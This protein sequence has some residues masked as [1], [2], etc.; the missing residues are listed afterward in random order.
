MCDWCVR[1]W[2]QRGQR[3]RS[4]KTFGGCSLPQGGSVGGGSAWKPSGL[5][6]SFK[7]TFLWTTSPGRFSHLLDSL[8]RPDKTPGFET[9]VHLLSWCLP[10][11]SNGSIDFGDFDWIYSV[12]YYN[13]QS[14]CLHFINCTMLLNC[15]KMWLIFK[16]S[17]F[18]QLF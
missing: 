13:G 1:V 16:Y 10:L 8:L 14:K 2:L 6:R 5:R 4:G 12:R 15:S 11:R 9:S 7:R 3:R 18:V 17:F